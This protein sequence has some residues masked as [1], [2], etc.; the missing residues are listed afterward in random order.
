MKYKP[1][2]LLSLIVWFSNCSA[3]DF[4]AASPTTEFSILFSANVNGELEPCG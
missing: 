4:A 2:V 1:L 3:I